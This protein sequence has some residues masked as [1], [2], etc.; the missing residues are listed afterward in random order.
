MMEQTINGILFIWSDYTGFVPICLV[1][2]SGVPGAD[3]VCQ[4]S[5]RWSSEPACNRRERFKQ[6]EIEQWLFQACILFHREQCLVCGTFPYTW[7]PSSHASVAIHCTH[8]CDILVPFALKCVRGKTSLCT[9]SNASLTRKDL[10]YG[11][12]HLVPEYVLMVISTAFLWL[13]AASH[14]SVL[15]G[16]SSCK[17]CTVILQRRLNSRCRKEA[18]GYFSDGSPLCEDPRWPKCG[19]EGLLLHLLS[20]GMIVCCPCGIVF[21]VTFWSLVYGSRCWQRG[22]IPQKR[23]S[24]AASDVLCGVVLQKQ[25][26][27]TLPSFRKSPPSSRRPVQKRNPAQACGNLFLKLIGFIVLQLQ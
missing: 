20:N 8:F 21:A 23:H 3:A 7:K 26:T 17:C 24:R 16:S 14:A 19:L 25:Q 27:Q 10:W 12:N 18:A 13:D 22:A 11:Y 9:A 1:G 4:K 15:A 2:G 5:E 6:T